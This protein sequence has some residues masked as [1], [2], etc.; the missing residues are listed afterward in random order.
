[1]MLVYLLVGGAYN[2]YKG[3][4]GKDLVPNREFWEAL[5]ANVAAGFEFTFLSSA[6]VVRSLGGS[7]FKSS[8]A[9]EDLNQ[10]LDGSEQA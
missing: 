6:G 5:P 3:A 7:C 8:D 10:S 2:K 9:Y 1:M 4:T